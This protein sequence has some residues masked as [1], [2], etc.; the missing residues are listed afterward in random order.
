MQQPPQQE[1]KTPAPASK[2]KNKN[3]DAV[4]DAP[5]SAPL[6]PAHLLLSGRASAS[7]WPKQLP[8]ESGVDGRMKKSVLNQI[9]KIQLYQ[10]QVLIPLP[11]CCCCPL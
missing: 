2:G 7:N 5:K 11:C 8:A 9:M 1:R 4:K 10:I 6:I 3:K